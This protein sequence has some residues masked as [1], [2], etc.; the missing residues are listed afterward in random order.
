MAR[1]VTIFTGQWADLGLEEMCSLAK[2]MGYQ[3]LEIATWGQLNVRKAAEDPDYVAQVKNTL[4]KYGLGCWAI[5]AHLPGQCVGD[6]W[7]SRLDGFA[8][9]E[10]AG[11]P[12]EIRAW[13]IEEM[14]YAARAAKAMGVKVVTGFMGSPIWKFWYSFPQT[15]EEMVNAGYEEIK[16]LWTPILDEFDKCGVKFALEV[17]PTEIAFDYYSTKKLLEVFEYRETLGI[18]F[19]PSHLLWQGINPAVFLYDFADRVYH[20]HIKDVAVNLDGRNGILG[21]HITFGDPRR[22]WNFVS[23]GHGDVDFDKIIRVLND[24]KYDGPLSIEWEDSGMERVFG[25]TEACEFTKK[26][27]FSPS[28]IAF[29]DALKTD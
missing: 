11:K 29:D 24:K 28:D 23:P 10:L 17:H 14:K 26:I 21:S 16:R 3:G 25:G 6:L 1:P 7:D 12:E 2:Q 20:V 5:G 18:N 4:E 19:D 27:N 13:G 9:A 22:G 15:S 8:P